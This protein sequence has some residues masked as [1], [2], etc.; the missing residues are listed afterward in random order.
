AAAARARQLH[1][2]RPASARAAGRARRD[3]QLQRHAARVEAR[4]PPAQAVADDQ[5][6]RGARAKGPPV[7]T[8]TVRPARR[9]RGEVAVP[10][11][12]SISHRAAILNALASGEAV[13]QNFLAGD[14]CLST[15]RVLGALGVETDLE[16]AER[17]LHIRGRGLDG[18]REPDDVLDCGNSGTT[19][20]L[21]AGVLAG[22]PFLSVL[23][24]D[25]SLRARPMARVLEPLRAMGARVDGRDGGR[26][27]PLSVRGGGLRG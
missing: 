21:M 5:G 13:V 25:A 6:R 12:K 4:R 18:L 19:M 17:T 24:G 2:Q 3:D 7:T 11:D 14:D 15:L 16:E 9:L 10:G 23:T 26:L 22:Q 8:E 20:R 27:A 1:D